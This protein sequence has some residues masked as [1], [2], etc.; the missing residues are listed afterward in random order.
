MST[1]IKVDNP[2][3]KNLIFKLRDTN[4]K[5]D[6]FRE[7]ISKLGK[8]LLF[9]ALE[10]QETISRQVVTPLE[11]TEYQ[12]IEERDIVFVAILRAGLPMLEGCLDILPEAK[13]GFLGIKRDENTLKSKIYYDRVGDIEGKTVIILDPMIATG[14]SLSLAL[15]YIISKNPKRIKSLNIIASPQGVENLKKYRDVEFYIGEIDRGLN[16]KGYIVPG[17]GDAGDRA[18]NTDG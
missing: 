2:V 8:V 17:I 6:K 9:E 13:S 3:V 16:D 14:G 5:S 7:N 15:D 10:N 1:V 12:S 11:K 18:F 4:T